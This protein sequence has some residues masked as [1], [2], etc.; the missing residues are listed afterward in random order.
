MKRVIRNNHTVAGLKIPHEKRKGD[1]LAIP[2]QAYSIRN[3]MARQLAG[4]M[5][6]LSKNDEFSEDE[7]P[8]KDPAFDLVDAKK[9]EEDHKTKYSERR[10]IKAEADEVKRLEAEKVREA[11]KKELEELRKKATEGS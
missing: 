6:E 10:R 4:N 8:T 2:G 5:P 11:E 3:L 9:I 7:D 1:S